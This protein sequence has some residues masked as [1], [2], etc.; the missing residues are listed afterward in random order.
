[1]RDL[2]AED[3]I[4]QGWEDLSQGRESIGSLLLLIGVPR[5][6]KAGLPIPPEKRDVDADRKL[7]RLLA[8]AHGLEAHSQ[9]NS[10]I[11]ELV[12]FERALERRVSA[13][14]Q[15]SKVKPAV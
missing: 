15:E 14:R 3:L 13:R 4:R 8:A 9:Y 10:Y 7:Y 5:L 12:S 1:M 11:R 6:L 2:P